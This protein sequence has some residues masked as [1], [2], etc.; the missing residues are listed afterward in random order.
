MGFVTPF[1]KASPDFGAQTL[2]NF[3]GVPQALLI[4]WAQKGS[5]MAFPGL[6][7]SSTSLQLSL[8]GV[9]KLHLIQTGPQQLDLTTLVTAPTIAPDAMATN[10]VFTIGHRGK[11][12]VENFNTFAAFVTAL[13]ADLTSTATVADLA[14]TGKYDSAANTFTANRIA[15]LIND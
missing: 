15:V 6:L 9:G 14:A 8:T 1:G 3:A 13:V 7:A 2:V 4:D 11:Y 10:E 5:A 12:K